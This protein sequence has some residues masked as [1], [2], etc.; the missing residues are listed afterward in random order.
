MKVKDK[1][2]ISVLL[3]AFTVV[4]AIIWLVNVHRKENPTLSND[5]SAVFAMQDKATCFTARLN[6][7]LNM[8]DDSTGYLDMAGTL[9]S[10]GVEYTA[11]RA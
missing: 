3:A 2:T 9:S 7:Y 11:A 10:K 4:S 5:C 6:I 8:R 1:K